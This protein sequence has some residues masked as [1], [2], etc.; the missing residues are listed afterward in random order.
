VFKG[1]IILIIAMPTVNRKLCAHFGHCESFALVEVDDND[2]KIVKTDYV[3]APPHEPGLLPAWLHEQGASKVIAG[4]MG[5]RAQTI[6]R[7]NNIEVI[8]GAETDTPE[9]VV[10]AYLT[11]ELSVGENL[12]D[13]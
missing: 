6:F 1:G 11:G 5:Q 8:T 3:E 10:G 12:C 13:H 2:N 7:S 9:N 4:G